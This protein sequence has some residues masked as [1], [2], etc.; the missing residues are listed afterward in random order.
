NEVKFY[1]LEDSDIVQLFNVIAFH[2]TGDMHP[3]FVGSREITR[4][5]LLLCLVFFLADIADGADYRVPATRIVDEQLQT[6]R[7]K[8]RRRVKEVSIEG[9][10][11]VWW[12]DKSG[13]AA[14]AASDSENK[15]L[16]IHRPLLKAFGLPSEISCLEQGMKVATKEA[17]LKPSDIR[18]SNLCLGVSEE[19]PAQLLS[20]ETLPELYEKIVRAFYGIQ[21]SDAPSRPNYFGPLVLEVSDVESDE[22]KS[23]VIRSDVVK[24]TSEISRYVKLW[25]DEKKGAETQFYYGY[26]H[27]QRIW[28]Y[29]FPSA[30]DLEHKR[31]FQD[32]PGTLSQ[33]DHVVEILQ[34]EG[35]NAR[36][37]YVMIPH[38]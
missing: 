29:V 16:S 20:A 32:W 15:K 6:R 35:R 11:I 30:D 7:T 18:A 34:K 13:K 22:A 4:K 19:V 31:S 14:Q 2:E 9:D 8:A 24:E 25:L 26:T 23:T 12:V 27:G 33:F 5:E 10:Y 28:R 21:A 1:G 3:C 37:S 36:R 38:R 17:C